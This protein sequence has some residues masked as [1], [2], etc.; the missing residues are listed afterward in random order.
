MKRL[1]FVICT[2]VCL[3][4][5]Y[6]GTYVFSTPAGTISELTIPWTRQG[7][8]L[9]LTVTIKNTSASAHSVKLSLNQLPGNLT[10]NGSPL[11]FDVGGVLRDSIRLE[12]GAGA[13]Q[14]FTIVDVPAKFAAGRHKRCINVFEDY[15]FQ[16]IESL[17]IEVSSA[18]T[19][20][21]RAFVEEVLV[22]LRDLKPGV[23]EYFPVYFHNDSA[24]TQ[25]LTEFISTTLPSWITIQNKYSYP[26]V[27]VQ[28]EIVNFGNIVVTVPDPNMEKLEGPVYAIYQ[29]GSDSS[30][31]GISLYITSVA[32]TS[33]LKTCIEFSLDAPFT[34]IEVGETTTQTLRIRSNR[35]HTLRISQPTL[36][37]GDVEGFTFST[38]MFPIELPGF[39]EV[40]LPVTFAPTTVVPFVKYRY[41]ATFTAHAE[42]D[43]TSCD[44][45]ITL[46]GVV[47][48][49]GAVGPVAAGE[50]L[51]R[52]SSNPM[53]GHGTISVD[54][55]TDARIEISD[56]LG[57]SHVQREGL[58]LEVAG[59]HA[60]SFIVRVSGN[61]ERGWPRVVSRLLI[62]Q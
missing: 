1:A 44:P 3:Q 21:K 20:R 40:S 51:V 52:I 39:G 36:S 56:M 48:S 38:S 29:S 7:D 17:P 60:G 18:L 10:K 15:S 24:G 4:S 35:H 5:S 2:L 32:D 8:T 45:S 62:V 37:W 50:V 28:N 27:V 54:G 25:V 53:F 26:L 13:S 30:R 16:A 23:T 34:P 55:L 57:N 59:L 19:L 47:G 22:E 41:A 33:L 61:D 58:E 46:A 14:E 9:R 43:S 31:T 42:S 49:D 11:F 6:G 12:L